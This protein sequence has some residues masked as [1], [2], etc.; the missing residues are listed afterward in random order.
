LRIIITR[1][2]SWNPISVQFLDPSLILHLFRL[3]NSSNE[4]PW[5]LNFRAA[6]RSTSPNIKSHAVKIYQFSMATSIE[7]NRIITN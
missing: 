7:Y 6:G 4:Q 2:I 3:S 1:S 5:I